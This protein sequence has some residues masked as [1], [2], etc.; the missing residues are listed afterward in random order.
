VLVE[1]A[2]QM[3]QM[4]KTRQKWE[5]SFWEIGCFNLCLQQF[6]ES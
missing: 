1:A 2:E 3:G 6:D 5:K 4:S